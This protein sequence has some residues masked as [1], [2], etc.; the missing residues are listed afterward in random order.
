MDNSPLVRFSRC[1]SRLGEMLE[2]N[3]PHGGDRKTDQV[4]GS[5]NL[6]ALNID[7]HLSARAKRIASIP[8]D[9]FE[10]VMAQVRQDDR[11]FVAGPAQS[12]LAA[13]LRRTR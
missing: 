8:E 1:E 5:T 2:V 7:P 6:K 3:A 12:P 13:T 9:K 11:F 4:V 10:S